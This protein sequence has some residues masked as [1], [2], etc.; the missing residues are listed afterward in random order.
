MHDDKTPELHKKHRERVRSRFLKE[1]LSSFE[2]HEILELLLFYAVP[3]ADTNPLAHR[4]LDT[5]KTTSALY[6]A[7]VEQICKE[8]GVSE[9]TA[10]LIK[11]VPALA[12][13][14]NSLAARE[15]KYL[16]T[17]AEAGEYVCSIIGGEQKEVF[18]VIC[19]NSQRKIISFEILDEGT[20]SQA[21]IHPRKVVEFALR[22]NASSV[23]LAHNH[24]SSG[25]YASE[26]DRIITARLCTVLEGIGIE[27][28]DH[29]I[30]ASHEKFISMADC[31]LMPN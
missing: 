17:S 8:G 20:V 26:D 19:L 14:Y 23:I 24:P 28:T 13:Y 18:A 22:H 12:R 11:L 29:I 2:D 21:N 7:P 4:L 16:S 5:F 31:G 27:V 30:A 25:A 1:G 6:N 9:K 3:R 15:S 10:V